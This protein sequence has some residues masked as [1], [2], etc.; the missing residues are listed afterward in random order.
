[1]GLVFIVYPQAFASMPVSQLWAFLFFFMLLCLGL[2][3]EDTLDDASHG[4]PEL[5]HNVSFVLG[6]FAMV[7]VMVTS[8][9]D[10]FYQHLIR[11]FKR[12]ELF[13]LAV[14]CVALLLGIPCVMQVNI[15]TYQTVFIQMMTRE[16]I[17]NCFVCFQVGIY[18]FQLMDHY[19]AIVS[20]MFLAFFEILA[21]C[22]S[23][24]EC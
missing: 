7:E 15:I 13:V 24:G 10:E 17:L 3:S 18:V 4:N 14:C 23:Y 8:L 1:P 12:K 11:I 19:T 21:I 2:D 16:E 9:L 22:W 5:Q 20:I 6:Q